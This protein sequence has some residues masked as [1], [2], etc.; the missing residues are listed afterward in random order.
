M[1][2]ECAFKI[3]LTLSMASASRTDALDRRG[4]IRQILEQEVVPALDPGLPIDD[5]YF[6]GVVARYGSSR[7]RTQ[8]LIVTKDKCPA[9]FHSKLSTCDLVM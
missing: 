4:R 5:L 6:Q 2:I 9:L 1:M 8:K 7:V 3:T